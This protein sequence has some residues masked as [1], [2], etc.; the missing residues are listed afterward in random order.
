MPDLYPKSREEL[1]DEN[2]RLLAKIVELE[3]AAAALQRSVTA[4][5][6]EIAVLRRR[7]PPHKLDPKATDAFRRPAYSR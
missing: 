3:A 4:R 6:G 1:L 5:D 2:K 7:K